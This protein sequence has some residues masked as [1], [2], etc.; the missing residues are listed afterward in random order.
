MVEP[1]IL[2]D[3]IDQVGLRPSS[4]HGPCPAHNPSAEADIELFVSKPMREGIVRRAQSGRIP[5]AGSYLSEVPFHTFVH[6]VRFVRRV[7]VPPEP[8]V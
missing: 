5:L 8:L 6:E 7:L 1:T 3:F 4:G 2:A